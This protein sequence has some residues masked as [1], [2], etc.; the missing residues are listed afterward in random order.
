MRL[1][2]FAASSFTFLCRFEIVRCAAAPSVVEPFTLFSDVVVSISEFQYIITLC[3]SFS[4]YRRQCTDALC[5]CGCV[6][7]I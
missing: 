7:K 1:A 4:S 3:G 2:M 6:K 5:K